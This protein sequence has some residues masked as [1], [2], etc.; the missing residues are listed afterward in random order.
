[1][2]E[3]QR[4][5]TIGK[6]PLKPFGTKDRVPTNHVQFLWNAL[7]PLPE[8]RIILSENVREGLKTVRNYILDN[9]GTLPTKLLDCPSRIIS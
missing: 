4:V 3:F 2:E 5:G 9:K 1:M 7:L 6:F 8:H